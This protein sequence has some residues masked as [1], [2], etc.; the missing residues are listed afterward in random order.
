MKGREREKAKEIDRERIQT[1]GQKAREYHED[2]E[3]R[4]KDREVTNPTLPRVVLLT[5]V[6]A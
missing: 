2:R 4:K 6:Q 5:H 3:I 1:E